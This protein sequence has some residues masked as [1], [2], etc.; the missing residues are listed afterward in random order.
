MSA[1]TG[2]LLTLEERSTAENDPPPVFSDPFTALALSL[3]AKQGDIEHVAIIGDG[4]LLQQW[5]VHNFPWEWS[6]TIRQDPSWIIAVGWNEN[7]ENWTTT[8][9]LWIH[10]PQ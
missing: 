9:P 10:P 1:T 6:G 7:R 2:P 3:E 5:T 8:A 4:V